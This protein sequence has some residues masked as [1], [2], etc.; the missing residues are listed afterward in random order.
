MK[1]QQYLDPVL[2]SLVYQLS[3]G[4][5][6]VYDIHLGHTISHWK[7]IVEE[8]HFDGSMKAFAYH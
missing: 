7:G 6:L 8:I 4:V 5:T 3:K 2:G 1:N